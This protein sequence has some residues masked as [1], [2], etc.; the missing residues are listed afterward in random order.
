MALGDD[1]RD[2][3]RELRTE[4]RDLKKEVADL[5]RFQSWVMGAAAGIGAILGLFIQNIKAKLGVG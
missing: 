3:E 2:L 1:L 4:L 5:R